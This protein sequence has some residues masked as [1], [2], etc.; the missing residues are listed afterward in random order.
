[1]YQF[2]FLIFMNGSKGNKE[3]VQKQNCDIRCQVLI[4]ITAIKHT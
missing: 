4:A 3:L 2:Y 1:M